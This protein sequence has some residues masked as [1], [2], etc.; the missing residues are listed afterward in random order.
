MFT[1]NKQSLLLR[2]KILLTGGNGFIG[3][4]ILEILGAKY[5]FLAPSKK[6]LDLSDG[7]AV[8]KY[9]EKNRIEVVIHAALAGGFGQEKEKGTGSILADNLRFFFNLMRAQK[10]YKKMI[11]FG[12]GA[13][14]DKKRDLK[15]VK[16]SDFG[17]SV[18][19]DEYGFYKYICGEYIEK[20][21]GIVNL[22]LFGLYGR[23]EDYQFKFISN[24]IVKNLLKQKIVINQ[25]T[26]FDYLFIEDLMPILDY[27]ILNK[28]KFKSYNVTPDK[29]IDLITIGKTVN[30]ISDYQSEITVLHA[31]LN[32]EY[33]ADNHRLKKEIPGLKFTDYKEG[34][35][36]LFRY[37][38]E[39]F[40]KIDQ[41]AI[42]KDHYLKSLL[43]KNKQ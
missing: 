1:P 12:S 15:K 37:Y 5:K 34:I 36:K 14:Y 32:K 24:V 7:D 22:I 2:N 19:S 4:N 11:F 18:P 29:P 43:N 39:N 35:G 17:Q 9:L 3:R 33:T 13:Q 16:E 25:E 23:Y 8:Y 28:V 21:E 6:E 42:L 10:F 31:G 26:V 30:E 38:Q 20:T 41:E 40:D 27:F